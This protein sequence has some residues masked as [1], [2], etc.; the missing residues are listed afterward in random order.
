[1]FSWKYPCGSC[2]KL[3]VSP[4]GNVSVCLNDKEVIK[5]TDTSLEK[6]KN[7]IKNAINKRESIIE[8]K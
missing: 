3:R 4:Q 6:K 8:N 7:I 1:M 5:I 2:H